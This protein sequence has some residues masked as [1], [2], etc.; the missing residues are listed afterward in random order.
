MAAHAAKHSTAPD[1]HRMKRRICRGPRD[2]AD[3][4]SRHLEHWS[5]WLLTPPRADTWWA[6]TVGG[7]RPGDPR[8]GEVHQCFG[9]VRDRMDFEPWDDDPDGE[10]WRYERDPSLPPT[11]EDGRMIYTFA[12]RHVS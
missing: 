9:A 4:R 3:D 7:A 11:V 8:D 12:F 10:D 6:R 5:A 2:H 1:F